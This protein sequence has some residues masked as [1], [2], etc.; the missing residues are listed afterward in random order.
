M[1]LLISLLLLAFTY[2]PLHSCSCVANSFCDHLDRFTDSDNDLVFLGSYIQSADPI[3][4]FVPMQ[5]KVEQIY[6]GEI[7]TPD[8]PLYTGEQFINS[9]STV[10]IIAGNSSVCMANILEE[11]AIFAV[12]Y[13]ENNGFSVPAEYGY[14]THVCFISYLRSTEENKVSGW[15]FEPFKDDTISIDSFQEFF[16]SGCSDSLTSTEELEET[17]TFS[18]HPQPTTGQINITSSDDLSGWVI[19]LHDVAGRSIRLDSKN[20]MDIGFLRPGVYFLH[21]VKDRHRYVRKIVKI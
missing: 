19:D 13:R 1:R 21:F 11:P 6:S 18:V 4:I 20:S 7:V 5:F 17:Y 9:D 3:S 16:D 8:S 2:I 15:I 12:S 14:S 10:W